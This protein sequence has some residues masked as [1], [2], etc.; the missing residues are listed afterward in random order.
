MIESPEWD[1]ED[2]D[3]LDKEIRQVVGESGELDEDDEDDEEGSDGLG[4]A[5]DVGIVRVLPSTSEE[6]MGNIRTSAVDSLPQVTF[7]GCLG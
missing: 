6:E 4:G 1:E 3:E 5:D 2:D 7:F